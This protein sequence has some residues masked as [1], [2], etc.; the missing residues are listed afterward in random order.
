MELEN[1]G[2]QLKAFHPYG[3]R[4]P[5]QLELEEQLRQQEELEKLKQRTLQREE[6]QDK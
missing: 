2:V 3:T 5:E 6:R 4:S 1:E